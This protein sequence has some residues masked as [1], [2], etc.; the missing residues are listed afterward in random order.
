MRSQAD[1][2]EITRAEARGS[3]LLW[4][5]VLGGPVAW[6]MQLVLT[7]SLEEWFACSPATTDRGEILGLGV[8]TV[9]LLITTILT[10]VAVA[11][12][13]VSLGCYRKL[14][15]NGGERTRSATEGGANSTLGER[16]SQFH[17]WRSHATEVRSRAR[18]MAIAGMMN[19]VLYV[20]IILASFGPPIVLGVC[21]VSP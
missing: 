3:A 14:R 6:A 4:F 19:S 8:T 15:D 20:I 10:A 18:W 16:E 21:E 2:R 12:G 17:T 5:G 11:S 13:L 7:Y 1:A 9:A